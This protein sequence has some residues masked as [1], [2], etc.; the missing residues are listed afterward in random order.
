MK[1]YPEKNQKK[2]EQGILPRNKSNKGGYSISP[3]KDLSKVNSIQKQ[4]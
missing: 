4:I 3:G 2:S 1:Y